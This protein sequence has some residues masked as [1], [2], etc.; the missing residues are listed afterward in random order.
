VHVSENLPKQEAK[1]LTYV[2]EKVRG[3]AKWQL[4]VGKYLGAEC[5]KWFSSSGDEFVD[6]EGELLLAG[7]GERDEYYL[8]L[9]DL[10]YSLSVQVLH[11]FKHIVGNI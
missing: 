8:V 3:C 1:K 7:S 6:F 5:C 2:V 10:K 11:L 9:R 4:E